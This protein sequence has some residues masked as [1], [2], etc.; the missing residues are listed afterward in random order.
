MHAGAL[1]D[2][3]SLLAYLIL[4]HWKAAGIAIRKLAQADCHAGA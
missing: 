4:F 3:E 2:L 1:H